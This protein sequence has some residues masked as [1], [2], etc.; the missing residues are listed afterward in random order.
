MR[1][2]QWKRAISLTCGLVILAVVTAAAHVAEPVALLVKFQ[3]DVQVQRVDAEEA[4]AGTIGM[5]LVPGDEVLVAQGAQAIVLYKTGRMVKA[6][7]TVKIEQPTESGE[8]SLFANTVKTLGQVATT[9]ARTQPNR[10]GMIRPIAGAPVPIAPG[11]K[12]K[13][14]KVLSGRPTFTWF[15]VDGMDRYMVQIRRDGD[16]AGAPR[17]FE[18]GSDTVWTLPLSEAPLIPGATYMWTVGGPGA[19]RVAEEQR[20]TVASADD[21][22][23]IQQT[24]NGLV[25]AG[26]DPAEDGLFLGALA[27]RDAGL[28]YEAQRALDRIEADGNGQGRAFFMLRG[29]VYDALGLLDQAERAFNMADAT[30]DS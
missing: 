7:A 19:G 17:R 6:E 4:V 3:G 9:D 21:I 27:Y 20:F 16:N 11:N 15:S 24:L 23:L 25:E 28:Y 18:A 1:S 10:Q 26:I 22:A 12:I 14:V 2:I 13:I 8:S 5:Q 30:D 29:E